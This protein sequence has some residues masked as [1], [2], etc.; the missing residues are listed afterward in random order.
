M[1]EF[2]YGFSLIKSYVINL[3]FTL[4]RALIYAL[5]CY[6]SWKIVDKLAGYNLIKKIAE[7]KNLGA[8]IFMASIFIGLAYILGQM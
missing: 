2:S 6:L 8:A 1:E 5:S 4:S 7:E 3:V